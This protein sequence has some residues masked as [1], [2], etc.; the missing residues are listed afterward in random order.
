MRVTYV[1]VKWFSLKFITVMLNIQWSLNLKNKMNPSSGWLLLAS[2]K[3]LVL[4]TLWFP[5]PYKLPSVSIHPLAS[6]LLFTLALLT[7]PQLTLLATIDYETTPNLWTWSRTKRSKI[8]SPTAPK[9]ISSSILRE[10][11]VAVTSKTRLA[12]PVQ[13]SLRER[14]SKVAHIWHTS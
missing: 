9:N 8:A 1:Y 11:T 4:V 13:V 7:M 10:V 2:S 3:V 12:I 5:Y 6:L 14:Y